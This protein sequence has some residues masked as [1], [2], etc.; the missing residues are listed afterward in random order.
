M[1]IIRTESF[2]QLWRESEEFRLDYPL[3]PDDIQPEYPG[4][5]LW[6]TV[7]VIQGTKNPYVRQDLKELA[8]DMQISFD[9]II[10]IMRKDGVELFDEDSVRGWLEF[11]RSGR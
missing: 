11:M 7:D 8:K 3:N 2:Y 6:G 5:N 10:S 9:Q 4:Q 1:R